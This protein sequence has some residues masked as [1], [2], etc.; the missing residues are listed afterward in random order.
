[1]GLLA[2]DVFYVKEHRPVFHAVAEK[3]KSDS[4][5]KNSDETIQAA[6]DAVLQA[7]PPE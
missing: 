1:M 5:R 2:R 3:S 4:D 6:V 7:F